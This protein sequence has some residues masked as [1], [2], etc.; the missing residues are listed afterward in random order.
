MER[1]K[2]RGGK[3]F[4]THTN[5]SEI[6]TR[7]EDYNRDIQNQIRIHLDKLS[8]INRELTMTQ[9]DINILE[10]FLENAKRK[11]DLFYGTLKRGKNLGKI[12]DKMFNENVKKIEKLVSKLKVKNKRIK[13]L[14][15]QREEVVNILGEFD[16]IF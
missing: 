15:M 1:N 2:L 13:I 7:E 4:E 6:H 3:L 10:N 8:N 14:E 16:N 11:I 5:W 9:H 12:E